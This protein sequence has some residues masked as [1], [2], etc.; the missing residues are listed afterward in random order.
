MTVMDKWLKG[1]CRKRDQFSTVLSFVGDETYPFTVIA[2]KIG[3]QAVILLQTAT[4][5]TCTFITCQ[6]THW[7][8]A[9]FMSEVEDQLFYTLLQ[10]FKT[11]SSHATVMFCTRKFSKMYVLHPSLLYMLLRP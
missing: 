2:V 10:Q 9:T 4:Q 6:V 8:N 11:I 5:Q 7:M 3:N 1:I